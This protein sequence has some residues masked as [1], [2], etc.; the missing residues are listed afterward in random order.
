[1]LFLKIS[2]CFNIVSSTPYY[3]MCRK[4]ASTETDEHF[5]NKYY[6][7][8]TAYR[9][10]CARWGVSGKLVSTLV[11]IENSKLSFFSF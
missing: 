8:E 7:I 6:N 5:H 9:V 3:E 1:M 10:A 2:P 11:L 4:F